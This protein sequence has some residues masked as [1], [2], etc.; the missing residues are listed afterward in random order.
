MMMLVRFMPRR[1]RSEVVMRTAPKP[2]LPCAA[3]SAA[4]VGDSSAVSW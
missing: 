2:P 4:A 1:W 3:L